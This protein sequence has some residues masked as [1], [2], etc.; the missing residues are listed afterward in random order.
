VGQHP[1]P[2]KLLKEGATDMVQV[3]GGRMRGAGY[4]T[5]V[6]HVAPESAGHRPFLR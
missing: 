6:L 4:G 3:T 5:V 1:G 2:A